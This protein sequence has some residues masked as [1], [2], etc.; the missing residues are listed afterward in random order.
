MLSGTCIKGYR[1]LN[2]SYVLEKWI[3]S[4]EKDSNYCPYLIQNK[5]TT[6]IFYS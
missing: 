3:N 1:A 4:Y 2:S 5:T 6:F